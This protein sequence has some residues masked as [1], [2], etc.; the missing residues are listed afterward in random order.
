MIYATNNTI[1]GIVW[2]CIKVVFIKMA[3]EEKTTLPMP[4]ESFNT[5]TLL[6][7]MSKIK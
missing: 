2:V 1:L 3:R 5:F 6:N 7:I 4:Y